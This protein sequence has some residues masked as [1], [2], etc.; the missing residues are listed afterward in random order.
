MTAPRVGIVVTDAY[1]AEDPDHD[2]PLL[3]AALTERGVD[4]SAVVW[5]DRGVDWA[6][7]DLLVLRSPWDYPERM[8]ELEAWLDEVERATTLHNPADLV[9]WNLDKGYLA[10]LAELGV[11]TVPTAYC[12]DVGE[13]RAAFGALGA[14]G[15][16]D[17]V[18][19]VV[20]PA[21]SAGARDT[22]LFR[23]GDPGALALAE[24]ILAA[25][26]VVMVQPEV[27]ELSAGLE[28]AVYLVDGEVTH[29]IA[30]GAL[31]APGGGFI[32]GVYTEHPQRVEPTTAQTAF[33]RDALAAVQAATACDIP[34]Y[35]RIDL[36]D[37]AEHGIVLLEAELFEPALNL[38]VVP[39][40][41]AVVA[42]AVVRRLRPP[43]R[44][45]PESHPRARATV[46]GTAGGTGESSP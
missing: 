45:A 7:F 16:R 14:L 1:P 34:L 3:V 15:A 32:G 24:R 6:G 38:H 13:A 27:P 11:A 26:N 12:A 17:D 9:R 41:T 18:G 36:V 29:A 19:V 42:D 22:G 31:L 46:R 39:E 4:A 30:K 5:H 44:P 33:A 28:R 25:G 40:V 21:V 2:T 20:K 37:S 8:A 23:G 10:R 35:A 43:G